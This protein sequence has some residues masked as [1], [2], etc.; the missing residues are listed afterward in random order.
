MAGIGRLSYHQYLRNRPTHIT[1]VELNSEYVMFGK[2]M[3]PE[4]EWITGDAI[5]YS[6]DRFYQVAY[7]KPPFGKISTS[8]AY[9]GRYKWS[10]FEYK[11][12]EHAST[13]ASYG[14]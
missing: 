13:F 1:C 12:I 4:A 3:L 6:S 11:V 9:T 5:Q 14:A 8:D 10:E 2:R 7:G